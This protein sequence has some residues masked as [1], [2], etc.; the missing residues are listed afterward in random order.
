[1]KIRNTRRQFHGFKVML[2][3]AADQLHDI[4]AIGYARNVINDE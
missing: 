4:Y 3:K 1:M 2:S